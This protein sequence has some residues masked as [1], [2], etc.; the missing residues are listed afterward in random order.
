[1]TERVPPSAPLRPAG[2]RGRRGAARPLRRPTRRGPG[3]HADRGRLSPVGT[4][5]PSPDRMPRRHSSGRCVGGD[6]GRC[7]HKGGG[8]IRGHGPLGLAPGARGG[9]RGW[10]GVAHGPRAPG[11]HLLFHRPGG[12]AVR[13]DAAPGGS[14]APGA[15][16]RR[17]QHKWGR[18]RRATV[19]PAAVWIP[20]FLFPFGVSA[21]VP[22][23]CASS[24]PA[25]P[26]R[27]PVLPDRFATQPKIVNP[28]QWF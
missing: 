4:V 17:S 23:H 27:H 2:I 10:W 7:G 25:S 13:A 28:F 21:P 16:D 1:M 14:P 24:C 19:P 22:S 15:T 18:F 6:E 26:P 20:H 9:G 5:P 12:S 8:G 3:P 11:G